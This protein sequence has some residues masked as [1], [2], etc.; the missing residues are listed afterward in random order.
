MTPT[1][2]SLPEPDSQRG[3]GPAQTVLFACCGEYWTLGY[4]GST[5]SL[6]DV[7]GLSYIQRLLRHPAEEVHSLDLLSMP[8][9]LQTG[10]EQSSSRP[11]GTDRIGGL[12]DAGE[13]LDAK[14][15]QEYRHRLLELREELED[16]RELGNAERA[17]KIQF[18]I[19]LLAREISRAVG[20]GGRDRRAGSAA[21]RA[22]LNV[23]RAIKTALQKISEHD[24]I[25]GDLLGRHIRT[26]MFCSYALDAGPSI[27]WRFSLDD[28]SAPVT[29]VKSDSSYFQLVTTAALDTLKERTTFV[30][31]EAEKDGLRKVLSQVRTGAGR[32]V[33]ITGSPGV[34]KTRTALEFMDE[35]TQQGILVLAGACYDRD[36]AVPFIPF[37]EMFESALRQAPDPQTFRD[38]I[39]DE[40][41]EI[42]RL[43]PQLRRMFPD[44][45][46]P[47]ELPPEQTRRV[48]LVAMLQVLS[49]AAANRPILLFLD[50]LHW[51]DEGTL[52][53][54]NYL[55]R[56]IAKLPVMIL[57]T[58]RDNE[59]NLT[60]PLAKMLD[61]LTRMRILF[62]VNL[63]GLPESA[64]GAM[65]QALSG[66]EAPSSLV[67][68]IFSGTEGNPFFVE[69]LFRHLAERG[70]LFRANGEFRLDLR[71]DDLDIPQS[72][73]LVIGR[74]LAR[75]SAATQ[76][77]LGTAAVIGPSFA[78]DLLEVATRID[79][80]RLLDRVEEAER[81]GLIAGT[82]QYAESRFHFAHE[83][84]R[85]AVIGNLS[86][87]RLQRLHLDVANAIERVYADSAEEQ[88][89]DLAHHLWQ[90]G[91]TADPDRTLRHLVSATK[92]ALQQS[93]Y[94]AVLRH[95][96]NALQLLAKLAD[97]RER[98]RH[99]LNLLISRGVALFATE[100][101]NTAEAGAVYSRARELC[102]K[103]SE[104]TLLCSALFGLFSFH[105]MRGMQLT[106]RAHADDL[107][108]L[109]LRMNDDG[110]LV[111]A[112]WAVGVS[113]VFMGEF[114]SAL[115]SL[116]E[117]IAHYDPKR[118][119]AL[120]FLSAQDPLMSALVFQALALWL[121]GYPD[122]AETSAQEALRFARDLEYPFTLAWCLV[123]L[124]IYYSIARDFD[125]A[126]RLIE[127]GLSLCREQG[128][129]RLEEALL[130]LRMIGMAAE[131]K[132]RDSKATNQ[133]QRKFSE[134]DYE[135]R[136]TWV[137]STLAEVLAAEKLPVAQTLL[138]EACALMEK[139]AERFV[140][141]E[142]QRIRGE[143]VL[144]Q[145]VK[146]SDSLRFFSDAEQ[147]FLKAI[148][149]ARDQGAKMFELRATISLS[150]LLRK[151]G[152]SAEGAA[153]LRE[154][155]AGF[156]EGF[157]TWEFKT[158]RMLLDDATVESSS[159][160]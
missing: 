3:A 116:R 20:L 53:L 120:A 55:V 150:R 74:R 108:R 40:A 36:D 143:L 113:K 132:G 160:S 23:T 131:G 105:L 16:A 82:T 118:H 75:L 44:I 18:E 6:G 159:S 140:E 99:E 65:I 50:D 33:M 13:M 130:A 58:F 7:K 41:P 149:I 109:A 70:T 80:D 125:R 112:H 73:R 117:G 34:G 37:V 100:G 97:T 114:S 31:R 153:V 148:R 51:A 88:I 52:S 137:R 96:R 95:T 9:A 61:E 127:E 110:M 89:N 4:S 101:W 46:A 21:E 35:A 14:A 71:V 133:R 81:A 56:S 60:G 155:C 63:G 121:L 115:E 39:G 122:Q 30:G 94:E 29:S 78:F 64:V 106:T 77:V 2:S 147:G 72:L 62:Q 1:D 85:R 103:L 19:D 49:R 45:T 76:E 138:D 67:K 141:A 128:Y 59:L 42:A 8:G 92:Q 10:K 69:E 91:N 11:E 123:E 136:Q 79:P 142:I 93:A 134:I 139:N 57:G 12:G 124:S 146:E 154:T 144:R 158:A 32:V 66:Q 129:A 38:A 152:R 27:T 43:M 15:K 28:R 54:L 90:A 84:V 145:V 87:P 135:L 68:F 17:E 26:G 22:R 104:D 151:A 25:I 102:E 83:L 156:S 5:F 126:G 86:G 157:G 24:R 48:L 119:R 47:V 98:E 111:Q 107:L